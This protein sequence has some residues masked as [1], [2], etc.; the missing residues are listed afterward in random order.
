MALMLRVCAFL[1]FLSGA[2][3]A[4][5]ASG[6]SVKASLDSATLLMGKT[7]RLHLQVE[8]P[9]DR[10]GH[11]PILTNADPRPYATLLGDTVELSK[12]YTTDTVQLDGGMTRI[13]YHIPVQVFDSGYY[14]I[15]GLQ[16][17]AGADTVLSNPLDLKVVPVDAKATDEISGM[18]D[19]A[20]PAPGTW[21]DDVPDWLLQYWWAIL[22][23]LALIVVLLFL[24]RKWLRARKGKP[25]AKPV[26][27]PYQEAV[28]ALD[29]LKG[30][31]LWQHGENERY[32]VELTDILRR[33]LNR[34]FGVAAPEMTT[35]QFL[36]EASRHPRLTEYGD[37]LQRLLHLADFIKFAKGDSLPAENEE[38]F[39]I[40][41]R[42]V[43]DTRP[44]PEEEAKDKADAG[45]STPA[46]T[47]SLAVKNG[48][49]RKSKA[50]VS[51][52]SGKEARR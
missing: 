27:P 52:K 1:V 35:S 31:Q 4:V 24:I 44:T 40:V 21:L 36:D 14:H 15:P 37:E 16:Y 7:T 47:R 19:V 32:F 26:I 22:A 3:G 49:G 6:V 25:K 39:S 28:K 48:K 43:E 11:F 8:K 17:V 2:Q 5:A 18:T 23:A 41:R 51:R 50:K 45:S 9:K 12:S 20:E 29:E 34:R 10:P 38:A 42:F 46:D 30:K 13:S 33:Y